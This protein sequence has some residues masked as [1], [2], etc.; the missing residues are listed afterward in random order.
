MESVRAKFLNPALRP[1]ITGT[2]VPHGVSDA[3][4][5]RVLLV[6]DSL[7]QARVVLAKLG[8]VWDG[9][10]PIHA[11]SLSEAIEALRAAGTLDCVLLDLGLPDA[12]GLEALKRIRA[13][14]PEIAIVVLSGEEDATIAVLAVREGAQDYLVKGQVGDGHIARAI[15]YAIERKRQ[16]VELIRQAYFDGLTALPNRRQFAE[17]LELA[18]QRLQR[19]PDPLALLYGDLD[20]FKRINDRLGHSVGDEVL[21]EVGAR[22][23]RSV[24]RGDLVARLGGDEFVV[25]CESAGLAEAEDVAARARAAIADPMI[26]GGEPVVI[27]ASFGIA[28]A[29]AANTDA[30]ALLAAADAAMYAEKA[31]SGLARQ[32]A[33][34]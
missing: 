15:L 8:A 26:A 18:V 30:G 33:S 31:S 22:L 21:V 7:I 25:L 16:E 12:D 5:P 17:Q 20:G 10:L 32:R 9:A 6:E 34:A 29:L 19:R 27:S 14:A 11:A 28:T 13:L 4:P 1:P 23:R 3:A 24:R 2:T